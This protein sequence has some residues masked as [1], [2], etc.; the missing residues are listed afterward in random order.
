MKFRRLKSLRKDVLLR[1]IVFKQSSVVALWTVLDPI[2]WNRV[3]VSD[4]RATE[5]VKRV[6]ERVKSI[7]IVLGLVN[8]TALVLANVEAYKTRQITTEYGER[9]CHDYG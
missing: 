3:I 4:T 8:G 2:F 1:S 7:L 9:Y 6:E 5:R